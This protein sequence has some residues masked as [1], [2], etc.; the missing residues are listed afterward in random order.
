MA[1]KIKC[2]HQTQVISYCLVERNTIHAPSLK[3]ETA[4]CQYRRMQILRALKANLYQ[5]TELRFAVNY[6]Y[7]S[8]ISKFFASLL[9]IIL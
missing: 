2:V 8:R 3:T 9:F 7:R 5:V 6:L 4:N 1:G